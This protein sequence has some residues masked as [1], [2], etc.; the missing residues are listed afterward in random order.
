MNFYRYFRRALTLPPHV[1]V[2][3]IWRKARYPWMRMYRRAHG[4]L[5]PTYRS[6]FATS[7]NLHSYLPALLPFPKNYPFDA[8]CLVTA[9]VLDHRFTHLG[10]G[11]T[12]VRHGMTCKGF[13]GFRYQMGEAI[14]PDQKGVW[15]ESRIN[16]ANLNSAKR[17]WQLIDKGYQPIDWYIDFRSGYRWSESQWYEDVPFAFSGQRNGVDIKVP[18]ELARLQHLPLLGIAFQAASQ[19]VVGFQNPSVYLAEFKN[20]VIDFIATNPPQ[21]GVNWSCPMEIAIRIA[22]ILV[23]F[24][25]FQSGGGTFESE[26]LHELMRSVSQHGSHIFQNLEWVEEFRSNHYLAN[27]VGLL[28]AASYLPRGPEVDVWL[29]FSVQEFIKEVNLQFLDDGANFEASTSYHRLSAEMVI[30]GAAL[31]LGLQDDKR[32]A[33]HSYDFSLR[34][35]LPYLDP[36]PLSMYQVSGSSI[37]MEPLP[38][39]LFVRIEKMAEFTM[40]LTHPQGDIAQFGDND[41]GR[42]LKFQIDLSSLDSPESKEKSS[43]NF[44]NHRHFVA[45]VNG[46]FARNDFQEFSGQNRV[47][48]F[49]IRMMCQG[50]S[51]QSFRCTTKNVAAESVRIHAMESEDFRK[52]L[53][54]REDETEAKPHVQLWGYPDYGGFA[55]RSDR[56]FLAIRCGSVGQNGNGGHAHNDGLSF[57]L[58]MDG[59]KC[60]I[61]PGTFVY[62]PLP[63]QRNLFRSTGAHNTVSFSGHDQHYFANGREGL[64]Q[65]LPQS[66][67]ENLHFSEEGFCGK[68]SHPQFV[69][70]RFLAISESGIEGYDICVSKEQK[71][72]RFHVDPSFSPYAEGNSTIVLVHK[73]NRVQLNCFSDSGYWE[74]E[75]SWYSPSYGVVHSSKSLCLSSD[76]EDIRWSI[77]FS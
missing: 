24:D 42:F 20:E 54:F 25:I 51:I 14:R 18:W 9:K 70:R 13:G 32:T 65:L 41:S 3:K 2:E 10:S 56:I 50:K 19:G 52:G 55:F 35:K 58:S 62:T 23:A 45:T 38:P 63:E 33:L 46:L 30:Y 31:V 27:I 44:L 26:F 4:S 16:V 47:E 48:P 39:W 66:Q 53:N 68:L 8:L 17:I 36:A 67:F 75:D 76:V 37:E 34:E 15:L 12:R 29:A 7:E 5:S 22:N 59:Y 1:I 11:E 43:E 61:D 72:V 73:E 69:H 57:E 49:V 40:H 77:H 6:D 64:F 28:F 74:I 71:H 21:F 60:L